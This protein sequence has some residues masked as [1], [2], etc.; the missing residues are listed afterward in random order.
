MLLI[1]FEKLAHI[2]ELYNN[3]M[4]HSCGVLARWS[5]HIL[6]S[7]DNHGRQSLSLHIGLLPLRASPLWS[8]F[9]QEMATCGNS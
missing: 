5:L 8:T 7:N 3:K 2:E 9:S 4:V 6:H 1:F